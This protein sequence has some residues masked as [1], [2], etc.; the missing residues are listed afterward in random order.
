MQELEH[1]LEEDAPE[2]TQL[3]SSD[4]QTAAVVHAN[5]AVT[6]RGNCSAGSS[7]HPGQLLSEL[8]KINKQPTVNNNDIEGVM[9]EKSGYPSQVQIYD[10]RS[11]FNN[12]VKSARGA[13]VLCLRETVDGQSTREARKELTAGTSVE[14]YSKEESKPDSSATARHGTAAPLR[15]VQASSKNTIP[16]TRS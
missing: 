16:M 6:A 5:G 7:M 15:V 10:Q 13:Q 8:S 3:S 11:S 9:P 14:Q 2:A 4:M 12:S 1:L